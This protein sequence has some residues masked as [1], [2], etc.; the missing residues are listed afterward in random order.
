MPSSLIVD[1][2][3]ANAI[4]VSLPKISSSRAADSISSSGS[5]ER[6]ESP[7]S[8]Q[9][10]PSS[11]PSLLARPIGKTPQ[12][13]TLP[14]TKPSTTV[15]EEQKSA[16]PWSKAA[17]PSPSPSPSAIRQPLPTNSKVVVVKSQSWGSPNAVVSNDWATSNDNGSMQQIQNDSKEEF[18]SLSPPPKKRAPT[19]IVASSSPSGSNVAQIERKIRV[20]RLTN[21]PAD[22]MSPQP[23]L[24]PVEA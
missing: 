9:A 2:A 24:S 4:E 21:A 10:A 20:M 18:P 6:T 11:P 22:I 1:S 23:N 5:N 17:A 8:S 12:F 15:K 13:K 7:P 19:A 14:L 3:P 16:N